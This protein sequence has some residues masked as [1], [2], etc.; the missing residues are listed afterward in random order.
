MEL[1][2]VAPSTIKTLTNLFVGVMQNPVPCWIFI[3]K[4]LVSLIHR[5]FIIA[6]YFRTGIFKTPGVLFNLLTCE[7][8][9]ILLTKADVYK[10]TSNYLLN[11]IIIKKGLRL[12]N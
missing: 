8:Y 10:L 3:C 7:C 1:T 12:K 4:L 5:S 6:F 11:Q 2:T 9:Y